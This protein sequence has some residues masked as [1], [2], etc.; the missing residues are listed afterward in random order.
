MSA[1]LAL[2]LLGLTLGS[3]LGIAARYLKVEGNPLQAEIEALMPGSQCGQC[4]YP[5]CGGPVCE[6]AYRSSREYT[7][8]AWLS[9]GRFP[10]EYP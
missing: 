9:S 4:G 1:I 3:L 2:L 10:V 5:G 8:P 6:L 7:A